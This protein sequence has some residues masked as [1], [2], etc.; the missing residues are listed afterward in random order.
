MIFK[1]FMEVKKIGTRGILFNLPSKPF[2]VQIYCIDTPNFLFIVDS[3]VVLENQMEK[4]KKYLEDNNLL[5]KPVII[6]STH[7]HLDHI[8]GNGVIK[9]QHIIGQEFSLEGYQDTFDLLNQYDDY[10]IAAKNL[11]FPNMTF[12]D[13]LVFETEAIEFF[14]TPGHTQCSASCYDRVDKV[15]LVGDSLVSPLP[16]INWYEL[17]TFIETLMKYKEIEFNK[18]ILA[19]ELVLEDIK[20]L[21]ES[22]EYL[23]QFKA[24]NV[25]FSEF[26]DTHAYMYMWGLVNIAKNFSKAGKEEEARKFLLQ[27]KSDIEN[28]ILKPKNEAEYKQFIELIEKGLNP[29]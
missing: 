19:H 9:S 28:P 11:V 26:T 1:Q 13:K 29:I 16:S 5:T 7:S 24:L 10:K 22:I 3:G 23:K 25:D 14:H 17:D 4:V 2:S 27:A 20:F 12:S 15:L 18:M 21:D 8:A 6:F